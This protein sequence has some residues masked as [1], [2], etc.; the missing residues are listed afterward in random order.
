MKCLP[1][2]LRAR[3]PGA[4]LAWLPLALLAV[5]LRAQTVNHHPTISW[6]TN[7]RIT[8]GSFVQQSFTVGD[9]E[10][11]AGSLTVT[12]TSSNTGWLPVA[13]IVL[14]GSGASRTVAIS[15]MPSGNGV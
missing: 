5:A 12:A 6:I 1:R 2:V 13:S 10:T 8:T 7:Q 9:A 14:G 3:L 15:P 11:A 4:F